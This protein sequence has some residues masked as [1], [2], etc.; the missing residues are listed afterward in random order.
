MLIKQ[1]WHHFFY[2]RVNEFMK[3]ALYILAALL[4]ASWI[5]GF[6]IFK[7]GMFIHVLMIIAILFLMQ[8]IIINPKPSRIADAEEVC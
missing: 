2:K 3:L 8:A 7:T 4:A 5:I 6:F 1:G